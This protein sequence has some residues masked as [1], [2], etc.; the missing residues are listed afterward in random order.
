A[1]AAFIPVG[2]SMTTAPAREATR[3]A[4][5]VST[6]AITPVNTTD[7]QQTAR[8][9]ASIASTSPRR[10]VGVKAAASR[11]LAPAPARAPTTA[12]TTSDTGREFSL[13]NACLVG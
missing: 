7:S 2:S 13:R 4:A 3:W 1:A 5:A 11:L 6:T 10:C 8:T 9:S 12:Y